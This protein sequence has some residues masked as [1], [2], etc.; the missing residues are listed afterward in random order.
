LQW[1]KELKTNKTKTKMKEK[2][3]LSYNV[4]GLATT[5]QKADIPLV[6]TLIAATPLLDGMT[7]YPNNKGSEPIK[8]LTN[9]AVLQASSC[10]FSPS[11]DATLTNKTLTSVKVTDQFILCNED[12]ELTWAQLY[13]KAGANVENLDQNA[14]VTAILEDRIKLD[15]KAWENLLLL[16]DTAS[17]NAQLAFHDGLFKKMNASGTITTV[18]IPVTAPATPAVPTDVTQALGIVNAV[19]AGFPSTVFDANLTPEIWVSR[20]V[21]NAVKT[22]IYNDNN[23]NFV[24]NEENI[25]KEGS[26]FFL[27]VSGVKIRAVSQL[28]G[29]NTT[30]YGV[31]R[32]LI[33]VAADLADDVDGMKI[34][35]D[36]LT[37][38]LKGMVKFRSGIEFALDVNFVKTTFAA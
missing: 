23:F 8:I 29:L 30:I 25:N 15:R 33:Y 32:E 35:P 16:G 21:Y 10:T 28:A 37:D 22:N 38:S 5:F 7:I 3:K 26:S 1:L 20:A 18:T 36:E 34:M 2:L 13:L 4:A 12:L 14:L 24:L 9:V 19:A 27:P 11:G 31:V 6:S 17:G